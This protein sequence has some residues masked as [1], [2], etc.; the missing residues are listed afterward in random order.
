MLR[1]SVLAGMATVFILSGCSSWGGPADS[2]DEGAVSAAAAGSKAPDG[3]SIGNLFGSS[4]GP[5]ETGYA[6]GDEP[7]A[8]RAGA[9]MLDQGGSAADAATTMYFALS[10]TYPVAAGLGGG[11][12]CVVYDAAS[13]RSRA[14]DFLARDA[15]GGGAFA[16]PGNVR[17]F[18]TLQASFGVLPWSRDVAP[19]E[20]MAAAGFPISSALAK[21]LRA[22]QNVIRLDA[23][24]AAEFLDEAG[25]VKAQGT[26]VASP[27]LAATL[28]AIR[29][30]GADALYRGTIAETIVDYAAEEN[31]AISQ[32]DLAGYRASAREPQILHMGNQR[33]Y[34]SPRSVGAGNFV[35][36]LL[37]RLASP[38]G[39]ATAAD[40][41]GATRRAQAAA[42]QEFG[43]QNLPEDLGATGFAVR[44]KNGQ[45]VACA[46]TMNGPFGSGH[47]ARGTGVTLANAPAGQAGLA[48]AFLTP[49]VATKD[50]SGPLTL[51]GENAAR[52][53]TLSGAGA[54]GPNGAA[55]IAYALLRLARGEDMTRPRDLN[56]GGVADY[57]SV[58]AIVCQNGICA[59]LPD[60]GAHGLG[61]AAGG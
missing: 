12:L 30:R 40:A 44:D 22:S 54:G 51:P 32:S 31:G 15:A 29:A 26:I 5:N 6:V 8:V 1:S 41:D 45:A 37:S 60:S 7:Y 11:G 43:V 58:N 18:A 25:Q 20:S 35:M 24:L 56:K 38:D 50:D 55:T 46:V 21:R 10:A 48:A 52:A 53:V 9:D 42:L 57:D 36:A 59:V 14:I 33:I 49:V 27:A 4:S 13:G 23:G 28:A 16:V 2:P 61:A 34:L 17:G 47:T 19:G 3:F 39:S